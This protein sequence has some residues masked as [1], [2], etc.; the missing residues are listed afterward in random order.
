MGKDTFITLAIHT[1]DR[2]LIVKDKLESYGI[3][4]KLQNVNLKSPTI[5]SGVRVRIPEQDLPL[6]LR[7]VEGDSELRLV[8]ENATRNQILIPIDFSEN[9]ITA[10]KVGFQFAKALSLRPILLHAFETPYFKGSLPVSDN[11]GPDFKDTQQKQNI[12]KRAYTQMRL[13]AERLHRMIE[14]NE[15]ADVR[16]SEII[17]EGVPEEVILNYAKNYTP[18]LIVMATRGLCQKQEDMIG[19]VTAE[20][21]DS[22][23]VP[24]FTLP[25]GCSIDDLSEVSRVA[26]LCNLEHNDIL[27]MDSFLRLF[28]YSPLDIDVVPVNDKAGTKIY[29][30]VKRVVN[31]FES[32]YKGTNFHSVILSHRSFRED[33]QSL[34]NNHNIKLL[35]VPN[36]KKNIFARLFNPG[37][38]HRLLFE[39]DVPMLVLPI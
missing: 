28:K 11:F 31:Y 6:A 30:Q 2:A 3:N 37:M 38:A 9:S 23:R 35:V 16:F 33:V 19:S 13:F 14:N 20:V 7:I 17:K 32:H 18:S 22:C 34:I 4:V 5:S 8:K 1:Y 10:C 25:E 15:L 29:E 27:S 24:V 39:R 21:L 36:K 12:E 26:F